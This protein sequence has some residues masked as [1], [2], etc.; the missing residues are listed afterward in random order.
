[1]HVLQ[2]D[3]SG[4]FTLRLRVCL[5]SDNPVSYWIV[6]AN[7]MNRSI[8]ID[9]PVQLLEVLEVLEVLELLKVLEVLEVLKVIEVLEVLGF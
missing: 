7:V 4:H 2:L 1:M 9:I 6:R 5:S 3:A 8:G